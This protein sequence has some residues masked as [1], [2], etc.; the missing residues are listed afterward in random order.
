MSFVAFADSPSSELEQLLPGQIGV[1]RR[2]QPI[3]S[4]NSLGSLNPTE[5]STSNN[6]SDL[7]ARAEYSG[8]HGER[9]L[10]EVVRFHQDS[11][12][13]SLLSMAAR[14]LRE[15]RPNEHIEISSGKGTA[16]FA[17]SDQVVFFKGLHL[18]R[19]SAVTPVSNSLSL[20]TLAGLLA[21]RLDSGDGE[22]P[23]LIKHLPDWDHAQINAIY[24]SHITNLNNVVPLQEILGTVNTEGDADAVLA[25][26]GSAQLLLIEFNTPQLAGDNDRSVLAKLEELRNQGQPMPSGYRRVGNYSVFVFNAPSEQAAKDLIDQVKYEQVVQWL[27]ENP[28]ILKEAQ[29]RYVETTLGVFLSVI[30]AS[31]VAALACLAVGGVFG[32][33]L[34][35]RRR[36][37]QRGGEAFSDAGG[38][39]RLNIDELTAETNPAR[40]LSGRN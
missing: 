34:F 18:V 26:Y 7:G 8:G 19:I 4:S 15:S 33:L 14:T 3:V 25:N 9:V 12:A 40:L 24:F 30:R 13:Y 36:A 16:G 21:A 32:G 6:P 23:V 28:N 10:V 17:T 2:S 38:M 35:I 31:G 37:Q 11:E 39:V 5:I 22:I 29:R 27:G 1:F 20:G